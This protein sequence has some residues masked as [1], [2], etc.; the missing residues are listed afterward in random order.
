MSKVVSN[1]T[2]LFLDWLAATFFSFL[3]N[4]IIVKTFLPQDYGFIATTISI[5]MILS[6]FSL[7]GLNTAV[8]KLIPE[9]LE[10][11]K[12]E[13]IRWISKTAIKIALSSSLLAVLILLI[14]SQYLSVIIKIPLEAFLF[15]AIGTVAVVATTIFTSVIYGHQNMRKIFITGIAGNAMKIAILCFLILLGF[16]Y[17]TAL[18]AFVAGFAVLA[19]IR[20]EKRN[21]IGNAKQDKKRAY[22]YASAAF[23]SSFFLFLFS[24]THY[25]ILSILKTPAATGIF[26]VAM[27]LISPISVIPNTL[28]NALFPITSQLCAEKNSRKKQSYLIESVIRYTLFIILPASALLLVFSKDIILF[29]SKPEYLPAMQLYPVLILASIIF[30]CGGIFSTSLYAIRKPKIYRN[31]IIIT[32]ILFLGISIP[33]TIMFSALG[34]AFAYLIAVSNYS[35]LNYFYIKKNVH[36][37][38]SCESI[39][40]IFM[41][42]LLLFLFLT[43]SYA[44]NYN[45]A[46]KIV[47]AALG[48]LLFLF[49]LLPMR[50]YK[51]DDIRLLEF[52]ARR[53]KI[54][55]KPLRKISSFVKPFISS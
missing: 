16:G 19:L 3:F 21:F 7:L 43:F 22:K 5:T 25:I 54:M 9:Y 49:L 20:F 37:R 50:F 27:L 52:F 46:I 34:L 10:K 31:V 28:G 8:S 14:S 44:Q 51:E 53:Y 24:N 18:I 12:Q 15:V 26:A 33:L 39:S 17:I 30:G 35:L 4:M 1:S 55:E 47:L 41:S 23:V 11:G 13:K 6:V 29:F 36:L 48:V 38:L 40:K 42:S 2:Y 45:F 32:A